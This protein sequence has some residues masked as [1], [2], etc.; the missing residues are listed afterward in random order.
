MEDNKIAQSTPTSETIFG[1]IKDRIKGFGVEY[2]EFESV[3]LFE[4]YDQI[5]GIINNIRDE[6]KPVFLRIHSNRLKSHSKGDDNR[7]PSLIEKLNE[8]DPINQLEKKSSE[9]FKEIKRFRY[10][11]SRRYS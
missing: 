8:L 1:S 11:F 2:I 10:S 5:Q 6:K 7:D 4:H 3:E 9:L